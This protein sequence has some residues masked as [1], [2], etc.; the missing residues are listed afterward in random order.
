MTEDHDDQVAGTGDDGGSG[1]ESDDDTIDDVPRVT[2]SRCDR[3][4]RLAYELDDLQVG[5]QALEQFA[6]D[7]QRHTGHFPDDVSP[8]QATCQRCP[9]TIERLGEDAARRWAA[10]H[11]RHTRHPVEL[12]HASLAEPVLIEPETS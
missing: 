9:E 1:I 5:N 12:R 10:I 3:E 6:L 8:W 2:C 7:H 4:W 11:G